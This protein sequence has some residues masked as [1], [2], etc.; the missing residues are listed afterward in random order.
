MM[1]TFWMLVAVLG[2][3]PGGLCHAQGGSSS[4]PVTS[5][6]PAFT[7]RLPPDLKEFTGKRPN[8]LYI[9]EQHNAD[10]HKTGVYVV[11]EKVQGELPQGTVRK[12]DLT[13]KVERVYTEPW[14]SFDINV[15]LLRSETAG[16]RMITR[17][18]AVPL[19]GNAIKLQVTG[20]ESSDA[21]MGAMLKSLLGALDGPTN[22]LPPADKTLQTVLAAVGFVLAAAAIVAVLLV[23]RRQLAK[24]RLLAAR[25]AMCA[26]K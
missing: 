1:R 16:A 20:P 22:W 15:Y 18:A 7:L 24:A 26:P 21:Q 25:A 2:L 6:D 17:N 11:I 13:G 3:L 12:E 8:V 5:T 14:K 10:D 9:W 19:K 23:R 4:P